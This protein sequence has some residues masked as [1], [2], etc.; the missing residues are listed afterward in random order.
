MTTLLLILLVLAPRRAGGL[1]GR[2]GVL[3]QGPSRGEAGDPVGGVTALTAMV[4]VAVT[5]I[6]AMVG[7]PSGRDERRFWR[8]GSWRPPRPSVSAWRSPRCSDSSVVSRAGWRQNL[9]TV[10]RPRRSRSAGAG[11]KLSPV[12]VIVAQTNAPLKLTQLN[13]RLSSQVRPAA[14]SPQ[15]G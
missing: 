7:R 4:I 8:R 5:Y 12:S 6:L 15:Q 13:P 2:P 14:A 10:R 11:A 3:P 9:R 1:R